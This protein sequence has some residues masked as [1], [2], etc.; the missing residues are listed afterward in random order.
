M[1]KRFFTIN[2]CILAVVSMVGCGDTMNSATD[3]T[4]DEM[5]DPVLDDMY[6]DTDS[7]M[8][9]VEDGIDDLINGSE[10]MLNETGDAI[11]DGTD[12]NV[13]DDIEDGNNYGNTD[14]DIAN[15]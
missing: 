8:N 11:M 13:V 15:E 7:I 14:V 2:M 6:N 3:G 9:D 5:L 1:M 4:K 10:N 12:Y